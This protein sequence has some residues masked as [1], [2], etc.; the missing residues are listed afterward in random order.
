MSNV[1]AHPAHHAF[2]RPNLDGGL[3]RGVVALFF[4]LLCAGVVYTAYSLYADVSDAGVTATSW[5]QFG[6]L[7]MALVIALGFEFVNGFHDTAN[8]V[9]TVIYTNSL[10]AEFAVVWSGAWN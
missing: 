2:V 5:V 9:A 6:L 7:G 8:A 1:A 4:L 3:N 10:K